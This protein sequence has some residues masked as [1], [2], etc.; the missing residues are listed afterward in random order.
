MNEKRP[1]TTLG[2]WLR[3]QRK[4]LGLSQSDVASA[5][6]VNPGTVSAWERKPEYRPSRH[7][8]PAL[9]RLFGV[10]LPDVEM[11]FGH[12]QGRTVQGLVV[13]PIS[14]SGRKGCPG[15]EAYTPCKR[16][17]IQGLPILCE[18]VTEVDVQAAKA[19]GMERELLASRRL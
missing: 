15:C 8:M 9:S 6:G 12:G 13:E 5:L 1:T 11:V 4:R 2:L 16:A 14:L 18:K 10:P 7:R 3:E 17:V 19:R